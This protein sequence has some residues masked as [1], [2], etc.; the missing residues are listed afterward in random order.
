MEQ[1]P[2]QI[3]KLLWLFGCLILLDQ[4]CQCFTHLLRSQYITILPCYVLQFRKVLFMLRLCLLFFLF[5]RLLINYSLWDNLN[6]ISPELDGLYI[7]IQGSKGVI[8]GYV[9]KIHFFLMKEFKHLQTKIWL[10]TEAYLNWSRQF[11]HMFVL[12]S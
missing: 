5:C 3:E 11:F 6:Y 7:P 8:S 1:T 10:F 4:N 12:Y 2:N 9:F